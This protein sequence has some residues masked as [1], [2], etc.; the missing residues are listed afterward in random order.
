M[1]IKIENMDEK[2][3]QE[4]QKLEDEKIEV[5]ILGEKLKV[6]RE[7]INKTKKECEDCKSSSTFLDSKFKLFQK[8]YPD[9]YLKF[10]KKFALLLM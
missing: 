4:L 9:E 1:I 3:K 7:E 6:E 8:N 2:V 5:N 10:T